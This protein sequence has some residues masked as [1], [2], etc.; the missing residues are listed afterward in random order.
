MVRG[1]NSLISGAKQLAR[2]DRA[3]YSPPA[4]RPSER[5]VPAFF[6]ADAQFSDFCFEVTERK[7]QTIMASMQ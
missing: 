6:N 4:N 3:S 7:Q 5:Q 1:A 2:P